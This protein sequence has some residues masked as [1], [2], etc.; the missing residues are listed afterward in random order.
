MKFVNRENELKQL[1]QHY[2]YSKKKQMLVAISGLRRVGKTTL[3][4]EF[5]KNKKS[6]YFF[7]YDYKSS[8]D[9]LAEFSQELKGYKIIT[10]FEKVDT[11]N[12]FFKVI[13]TRC[14]NYII[15]FDEFQNLYN[16]DKSIFSIFQ[17]QID[18]NQN[19]K[20]M[21]VVLG[22]LIGLFKK[23]LE[24]K[25][26]PLYGRIN[27]K[28]NLKPF[29]LQSSIV[30]L[31]QLGY[32]D[33]EHMFYIYSIFG[34]FP[35]YYALLEDTQSYNLDYKAVIN[36]LFLVNNAPLENEVNSILK[37]EFGK[38]S[39]L[40]YSILFAIAKGYTKLNEIANFT[41]TKGSSI[42]RY[43]IDLEQRFDIIKTVKPI[44][45]KKSTRYYIKHPI[46]KFW[47]RFI[48]SKFSAYN[49][50]LSDQLLNEITKDYDSYFGR[51]FEEICKDV[52]INLNTQ[53]KLPFVAEYIKN[54]WGFKRENT[55]RKEIEIDQILFSEKESK[56]MF[57]ECK[58]QTK[59]SVDSI[60]PDLKEKA[61]NVNWKKGKRK[62]YYCIIAKSFKNKPKQ[63]NL[64]LIDLE[65][66]K[67]I[68]L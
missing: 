8:K 3:V 24:D 50:K 45:N 41:N 12:D 48:Y 36:K 25:K 19:K 60:L 32:K 9:L 57:V 14:E 1:N 4:K 28:L 43:L 20:I 58:W 49:L 64:L 37:Q 44:N 30:A 38:R 33:I 29:T 61:E 53:K 67:K 27:Y 56:I 42:T 62:E 21:F 66:I 39:S 7:I 16:I 5:I 2:Q 54:W 18:E 13:Y 55:L 22:S 23:I 63:D 51:T 65:D 15:V 11:W 35:K 17:K 34:G 31:K 52:L 40:Y 59:V 68:Y 10:E 26:E 6:L 46:L 47:F